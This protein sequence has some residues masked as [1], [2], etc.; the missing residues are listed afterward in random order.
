MLGEFADV[1]TV[2]IVS[3]GLQVFTVGLLADLID[4]RLLYYSDRMAS[5]DGDHAR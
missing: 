4:R 2:I 3:V 1:S 5:N